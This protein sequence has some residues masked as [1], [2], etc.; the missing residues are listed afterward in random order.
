VLKKNYKIDG[1]YLSNILNLMKNKIECS[2]EGL[3]INDIEIEFPVHL[4]ELIIHFGEPSRKEF[5]MF[6]RI[7]WDELGI[8]T[9]YP[10]SDYI[11]SLNFLTSHHHQLNHL[12][13]KLSEGNI[14]II[15]KD[16][17]EENFN[18]TFKKIKVKS[19]TFKGESKPY[20]IS[21]SK[22]F[23]TEEK[24]PKNKYSIKS[25]KE[26]VIEFED[27]GFKLAVIQVLMY[28]K[29]ILKPKFDL[30][31]F[32]KWYKKRRID[33]EMEGYEP[34]E[35]VTNYFRDLPIPKK[36][37]NEITEIKIFADNQIYSQLIYFA[38][39]DEDYWII[40]S[41]KDCLNFPK[42]KMIKSQNIEANLIQEFNNFGIEID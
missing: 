41:A 40:K 30:Y 17:V 10:T 31:E 35:E 22:K 21:I 16:K 39:G 2:K 24:T 37:A 32:V 9:S 1:K 5:D 18:V 3:F 12:P 19:C 14:Y 4:N 29:K 38:E 11:V 33:I 6:W 7:I 27:F 28:E 25:P 20:C 8:Y 34:I 23:V 36:Y 13:Q 26:E 42:L 15:A